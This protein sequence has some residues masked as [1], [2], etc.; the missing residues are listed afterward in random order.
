M[1]EPSERKYPELKERELQEHEKQQIQA[2][3][4]RGEQDIYSIARQFS[5]STSQVAGIKAHLKK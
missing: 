2:L 5:C 3:L 1:S 4:L